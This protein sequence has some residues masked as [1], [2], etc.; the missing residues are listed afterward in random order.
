MK[1]RLLNGAALAVT[2]SLALAGSA[3]AAS[4][5]DPGEPTYVPA[6]AGKIDHFV[7]EYDINLDGKRQTSRMESW[8]SADR[9]RTVFTNGE[10]VLTEDAVEGSEWK[11][12]YSDVNEIRIRTL[13]TPGRPV[14]HNLR[15][16]AA[17]NREQVD[18]GWLKVDGET[19]V[20]GRRALILVDGPK[21]PDG[22]HNS[23]RI[24][25]DADS[26]VEL[27][28]HREANGIRDSD[29]RAIKSVSDRKLVA[30]ETLDLAGNE[31]SLVFGDHPGATV[32]RAGNVEEDTYSARKKSKAAKKAKVK[33][34]AKAKKHAKRAGRSHRAKG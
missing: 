30:N 9:S 24:V 5:L 8:V 4:W 21:D 13:K 27:S 7:Y 29:G 10:G 18:T 33:K 11:V 34:K 23:E 28:A 15:T 25:V 2:A 19:T 12:F 17:I 20:D 26:Y 22:D 14:T 6:P 1:R 16:Q 32:T 3:S 31:S